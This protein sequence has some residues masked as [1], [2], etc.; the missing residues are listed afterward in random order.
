M[1]KKNLIRGG[2]AI[3][4]LMVIFLTTF[5]LRFEESFVKS[6][7]ISHG[8]EHQ[9]SYSVKTVRFS[10]TSDNDTALSKGAGGVSVFLGTP[11]GKHASLEDDVDASVYGSIFHANRTYS[12]PLDRLFRDWT[13]GSASSGG[14]F[15][16]QRSGTLGNERPHSTSGSP[17][18]PSSPGS[19]PS[20]PSGKPAENNDP[21]SEGPDKSDHSGSP[22]K[23]KGNSPVDFPPLLPGPDDSFPIKNDND[24][25]ITQPHTDPNDESNGETPPDTI[26]PVVKD[27]SEDTNKLIPED[28]IHDDVGEVSLGG[29]GDWDLGP[30]CPCISPVTSV[31]TPDSSTDPSNNDISLLDKDANPVPEPETFTL[32]LIGFIGLLVMVRKK[33]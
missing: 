14:S 23:V 12:F 17:F 6:E 19:R 9:P 3:A 25:R 20:A 8:D 10:G 13:P 16:P 30:V 24:D 33:I 18:S 29:T 1:S 28:I 26:T 7:N 22:P 32:F 15:F 31:P 11:P 21:F 4:C 27:D 5:L 2:I